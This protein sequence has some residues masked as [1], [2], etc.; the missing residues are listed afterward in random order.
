M[1]SAARLAKFGHLYIKT[2]KSLCLAPGKLLCRY[3]RRKTVLEASGG[4]IYGDLEY[5]IGIFQRCSCWFQCQGSTI[6]WFA[7]PPLCSPLLNCTFEAGF[8]PTLHMTHMT[9]TGMQCAGQMHGHRACAATTTR[10]HSYCPCAT[11]TG[12][13][14]SST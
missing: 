4:M 2:L 13:Q 5:D 10:V 1:Y 12:T 9:P 3:F 8:Q 7:L 6:P 14:L 11:M